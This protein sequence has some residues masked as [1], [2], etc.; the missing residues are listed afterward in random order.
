MPQDFGLLTDAGNPDADRNEWIIG[1]INA[2]Y[3]FFVV[4]SSILIP[5]SPYIAACLIGCW[6]TD[7]LNHIFGRRGTLFFC[8][9]FCTLSVIGQGVAQTWPQLLVRHML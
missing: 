9:I 6:L 4:A 1:L 7:P 3:V 5:F 8:G 2:G